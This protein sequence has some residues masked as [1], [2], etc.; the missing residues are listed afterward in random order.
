M[1][2]K[3]SAYQPYTNKQG[4]TTAGCLPYDSNLEDEIMAII[5][6]THEPVINILRGLSDK[7]EKHKYK[8]ANLHCFTTSVICQAWRNTENIV[9]HTGL[10]CIDIDG[11]DNPGLEPEKLRNDVFN[12][13]ECAASFV[14][15]SGNGIA[16]IF[17]IIPGHHVPCFETLQGYFKSIGIIVDSKCVD[18]V[19]LRFASHDSGAKY[20][21]DPE[22]LMPDL[23]YIN[24]R[25][26]E[27][28]Y[29]I[30]NERVNS[31]ANFL[32][33]VR[34]A[35]KK[36]EFK[37]GARHW[38]L[39][40]IASYCNHI[41]MTREYCERFTLQHYQK[42][43]I[44]PNQINDLA[45]SD[46][47]DPI[48][49]VYRSYKKQFAIMKPLLK[50]YSISHLKWLLNLVDKNLLRE[51]IYKFGRETFI[52]GK[53]TYTVENKFSAFFMHL[54]APEM[55]WT[56]LPGHPFFSNEDVKNNVPDNA[57]LDSC[58]GSRV[59]CCKINKTPLSWL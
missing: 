6:G 55:T 22:L 20:R 23:K 59:W 13:P 51:Y 2:F 4:I 33:G 57:F 1:G 32:N 3:L 21:P 43:K 34:F 44:S 9:Q 52:G 53:E 29:Y 36:Y 16:A 54:L 17:H 35:N 24:S 48:Q 10:I 28:T 19:R 18:L 37:V 40:H 56:V 5:D 26:Q 8:A 7:S 41:G 31:Y 15:A 27:E 47:L 58:N 25:Q 49:N 12:M 14:S 46:L 30:P 50:P 39:M 11:G 42:D 45:D 38:H